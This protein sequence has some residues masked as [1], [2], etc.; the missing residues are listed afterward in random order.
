[1]PRVIVDRNQIRLTFGDELGDD[2]FER[3]KEAFSAIV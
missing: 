2:W 3:N 1:M